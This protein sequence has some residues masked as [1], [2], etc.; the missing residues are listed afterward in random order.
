MPASSMKG[1]EKVATD[2]ANN[3]WNQRGVW[4]HSIQAGHESNHHCYHSKHGKQKASNYVLVNKY[5]F[6]MH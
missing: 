1:D 6:H 2:D 4:Q 5:L 3:N